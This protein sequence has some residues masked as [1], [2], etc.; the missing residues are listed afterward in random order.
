MREELV[1]Q[2]VEDYDADAGVADILNNYHE[3]QFAGGCMEDELEPTA[4]VFY[5][6]FDGA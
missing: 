5:D 2:R 4:K 6:M 3:G 1:R